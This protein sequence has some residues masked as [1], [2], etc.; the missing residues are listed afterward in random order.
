MPRRAPIAVIRSLSNRQAAQIFAI[1]LCQSDRRQVTDTLQTT[2]PL[3]IW[4]GDRGTY[5]MVTVTGDAAE[6][7]TTHA[8]LHRMEFGKARGFGSVK[9]FATIGNTGWKTSVFPIKLDD[10]SRAS[11]SW[12]LLVSKKVMKLENL[13]EGD[14]VP[15]TLEL[16]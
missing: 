11:K 7:I 9:C 8:A 14:P 2:L 15:L 13:A 5:A 1:S 4:R 3:Q 12:T 6:A 10:M 16:L